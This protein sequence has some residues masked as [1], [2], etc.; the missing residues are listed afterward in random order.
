MP[1]FH[2]LGTDVV[3]GLRNLA[4][5]PRFTLTVVAIFGMAILSCTVAYSIFD[6]L[7]LRAV[8]YPHADQ[9]VAIYGTSSRAEAA[10]IP[11]SRA[12]A[13]QIERASAFEYV[14]YYAYD[15]GMDL[16]LSGKVVRTPD[17]K[18]S[19][20]LLKV[21]NVQPLLGRPFSGEDFQ[22]GK[23]P[24]VAIG[25]GFWR[26]YFASD[27][28]VIGRSIRLSGA[29][30]TIVAV[31]PAS[32]RFPNAYIQL[33]I[34]DVPPPLISY[35]NVL[36]T[37]VIARLR[38]GISLETAQSELP[39]IRAHFMPSGQYDLI[40]PDLKIAAVSLKHQV[41]GP[42]ETMVLLMSAAV[43]LVLLMACTNVGSLLLVR[44]AGREREIAIRLLL[45]ASRFHIIRGLLTESLLLALMG[46]IAGFAASL[47]ALQVVQGVAA[48]SLG[49]QGPIPMDLSVVCFAASLS[50][51]CGIFFGTL[52][53]VRMARLPLN[54]YLREGP[55]ASRSGFGLF[56]GRKSQT[57]LVVSQVAIAVVL[58]IGFGLLSRSTA[59][60]MAVN[61]G[62]QPKH[63]L[64]I[65]LSNEKS[66]TASLLSM[67]QIVSELRRVP[68]VQGAAVG[69]MRP[70]L[71]LTFATAF[72]FQSTQGDWAMSP[73]VEW[74]DVSGD[75]FQVMGIPVLQGRSFTDSD[76]RGSPC[77]V[78]VSSI[79]GQLLWPGVSP[80]GQRIDLNGGSGL[81]SAPCQV[82][83]VV[84]D[85]RD[86]RLGQAAGPEIYFSDLQHLG[87]AN[88]TL[89]LR[90]SSSTAGLANVLLDRIHSVDP[91]QDMQSIDDLEQ[92]VDASVYLPR[93]RTMVVGV[94]AILAVILGVTGLYGVVSF[95]TSQRTREIGIRIALGAQRTDVL[96]LIL[97]HAAAIMS[98]GIGLGLLV[99]IALSRLMGSIVYGIS[100]SDPATYTCVIIALAA[101]A[102]LASLLPAFRAMRTEPVVALRHE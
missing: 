70:L 20:N 64:A 9:L 98:I 57:I 38:P 96:R 74:Q 31:M 43:L 89:L 10:K 63:L 85:V 66:G 37:L 35:D 52:P 79:L 90:I 7:V 26:Q 56:T 50:V 28:A 36:D 95:W 8:P 88:H 23:E 54:D 48:P 46:G 92:I 2:S 17:V 67:H 62:F 78:V 27:P 84:G 30:Y 34:P 87:S 60:L 83:G 14:G 41:I 94:F 40:F 72:A 13:Q 102:L 45:G 11:F 49:E 93:L 15:V 61:L 91:T 32:F 55:V 21:L 51:V 39:V 68:G 101:V 86:T 22:P 3:A 53:A 82:V 81:E 1:F 99:T 19:P 6:L 59:R 76:R 16:Q 69:T 65:E 73:T 18:V 75:Y 58:A 25:S 4:K 97:R 24:T 44:N 77:S 80:V 12:Q 29:L 5:K 42:W 100:T 47:W 71:G 33:W